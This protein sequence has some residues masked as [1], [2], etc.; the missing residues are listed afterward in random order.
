MTLASCPSWQLLQCEHLNLLE[1]RIDLPDRVE[2]ADVAPFRAALERWRG[3]ALEEQPECRI[4]ALAYALHRDAT[5][6]AFRGLA[7]SA[8]FGEASLSGRPRRSAASL[9]WTRL[10]IELAAR[11]R[12]A[13]ECSRMTSAQ[14]LER[15]RPEVFH[16][17]VNNP[18]NSWLA[19]DILND[20]EFASF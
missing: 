20:E 14:Y 19:A 12:N 13:T 3:L 2:P 6:Q 16:W 5:A 15:W 1:A 18:F 8:G 4:A 10:M 17:P 9:R 7:S 11:Q